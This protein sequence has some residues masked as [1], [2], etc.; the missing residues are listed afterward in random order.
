MLSQSQ[1]LEQLLPRCGWCHTLATNILT[2]SPW[3]HH[4]STHHYLCP[5]SSL[6]TIL[7]LHSCLVSGQLLRLRVP[8]K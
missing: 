7:S 2:A 6:I 3:V 5:L 4:S 8:K 1:A